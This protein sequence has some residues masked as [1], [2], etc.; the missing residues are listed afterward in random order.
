[1]TQEH[2]SMILFSIVTLFITFVSESYWDP[3]DSSTVIIPPP[4]K[5]SRMKCVNVFP[6]SLT[7][8]IRNILEKPRVTHLGKNFSA[9][10]ETRRFITFFTGYL[11]W[12][13]CIQSTLCHD[14]SL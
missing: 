14:T 3:Q 8:W 13:R 4:P 11:S 5:L 12:A 9:F 1:L 7:P 6:S 10:Y 2:N